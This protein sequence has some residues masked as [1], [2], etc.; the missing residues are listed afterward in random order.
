M[1]QQ[2]LTDILLIGR[3]SVAFSTIWLFKLPLYQNISAIRIVG[4]L[5]GYH[6]LPPA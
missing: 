4:T 2:E 6:D 3:L 5:L 1:V